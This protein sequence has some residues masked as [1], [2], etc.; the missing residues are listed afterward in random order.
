MIKKNID[1]E[2]KNND[3]W[4]DNFDENQYEYELIGDNLMIPKKNNKKY[5]SN[6]TGF[7]TLKYFCHSMKENLK[8]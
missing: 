4:E 8:H 1:S 2:Y 7:S 3:D 5:F 6:R